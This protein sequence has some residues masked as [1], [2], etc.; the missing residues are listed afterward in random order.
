MNGQRASRD[1]TL[2]NLQR[3]LE[4][5]FEEA[6]N[7]LFPEGSP[8]RRGADTTPVD[9]LEH[10]RERLLRTVNALERRLATNLSRQSRKRGTYYAFV[11]LL[12]GVAILALLLA[13]VKDSVPIGVLGVLAPVPFFGWLFRQIAALESES[14][15]YTLFMGKYHAL[16]LTCDTLQCLQQVSRRMYEDMERLKQSFLMKDVPPKTAAIED[17]DT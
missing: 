8:R 4:E 14:A 12:G 2:D 16:I 5:I 11:W 7:P 9:P 10:I 3:E 15:W 6:R 17:K 1:D 13:V